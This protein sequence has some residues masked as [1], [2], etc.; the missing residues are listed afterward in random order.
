MSEEQIFEQP[1]WFK[2]LGPVLAA[3]CFGLALWLA[4]GLS[5]VFYEYGDYRDWVMVLMGVGVILTLVFSVW[6]FGF[7]PYSKLIITPS[8]IIEKTLFFEAA[9][10]WSSVIG[11]RILKNDEAFQIVGIDRQLVFN[12]TN[13]IDSDMLSNHV[14]ANLSGHIEQTSPSESD[15]SLIKMIELILDFHPE[16]STSK[17]FG[18]V[19]PVD[20]KLRYKRVKELTEA[21]KKRKQAT[22]NQSA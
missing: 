5:K 21:I 11:F 3:V 15:E 10:P 8:S 4:N 7:G 6:H 13:Y 19:L 16:D 17:V 22:S 2:R 18:R 12:S 9:V 1:L 14:K 20:A